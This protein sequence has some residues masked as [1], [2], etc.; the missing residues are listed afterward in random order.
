MILLNA[1]SCH[2]TILH[3]ETSYICIEMEVVTFN[4]AKY[5]T[6]LFFLFWVKLRH[7]FEVRDCM[8]LSLGKN[9]NSRTFSECED[10][11]KLY[12]PTLWVSSNSRFLYVKT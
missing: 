3:N 8:Y 2:L 5:D 9:M 10:L 6:Y 7:Y 4:E 1:R 11:T 12:Q